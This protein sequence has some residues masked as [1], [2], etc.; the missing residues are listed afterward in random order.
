MTEWRPVLGFEGEYEVS[1]DG[2]VRS[3]DR[4]VRRGSGTLRVRGQQLSPWVSKRGYRTVKIGRRKRTIASLVLEAFKGPRPFIGAVARHWND[5]R[6]DDSVDNLL[7]GTYG[8]NSDDAVRNGTHHNTAK[9]HCPELHE[10]TS[11]NTYIGRRGNGRT[12]RKC[13]TCH[14][15]RKRA[16]GKV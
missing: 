11:E 8:E 4:L 12:F 13:R 9:T 6:L 1:D 7:W 3:I 2:R 5:D 14:L 15:E 16:K 10:Y